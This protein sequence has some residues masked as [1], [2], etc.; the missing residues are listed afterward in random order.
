[1]HVCVMAAGSSLSPQVI[2]Y[3]FVSWL[4]LHVRMCHVGWI[5]LSP[6]VINCMMYVSWLLDQTKPSSH[7]LHDVCVMAAGSS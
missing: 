5:R 7:Q 2:N 3:M 4:Q 6:Q 1:M